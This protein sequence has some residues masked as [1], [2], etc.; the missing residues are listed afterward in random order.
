[1]NLLKFLLIVLG[2]IFGLFVINWIWGL[3]AGV[4]WYGALLAGI[5]LIGVGGYR[6]FQWAERRYV[7]GN[8]NA[9]LDDIDSKISWEEYDRKYLNK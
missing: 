5:I 7:T 6:L 8:P 9:Y 2:V 1:M 4:F 3:I